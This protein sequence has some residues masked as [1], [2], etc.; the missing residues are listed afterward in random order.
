ML[1]SSALFASAGLRYLPPFVLL[2]LAF[3]FGRTLQPGEVPLIER[4]ARASMP[5]LSPALRRYTRGLTAAWC[6][7]FLF[8]ALLAVAANAGFRAASFG[9]ASA[10]ALFFVGEYWL[11]RQ[12]LFRDQAFPGLIQQVRDTA[13]VWRLR[14]VPDRSGADEPRG[15]TAS[16]KAKAERGSAG[17]IHAIAWAARIAGRPLCRALLCPITLYFVVTDATA[18]RASRE[19]LSRALGRPAALADVFAHIYSFATTLLDR[20]YMASGDF[21]R[22]SITVTGDEL[23]R[24][25]LASGKGCVLLGSHLG[26]FD[27]MTLKNKVL[28][29]RPVTLLM[30][31][32][33]RSRVRRIA[34]ID[35][36]KL[37][38][39]PLGRFDSYLRAYEVLARGGVVAVLADRSEQ[40]AAL[41]SEF[42]GRP[43]WFPLGPHALAARADAVVLVGFGL[44]EGGARYRVEIVE[45][46]AP[47]PA[48]S[49]GSALQPAVDRYVALLEQYA[50]RYPL[51]WFNF[52]PYWQQQRQP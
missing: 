2:W 43:A 47:A 21:R 49:R 30:H 5:P 1:E 52:F 41:Q 19:F 26:S 32:D 23:V 34:G 22:F 51:N 27:L 4:I 18:R 3:F 45:Y 20:V 36:S 44:Y 10:S 48:G 24:D 9:V 12:I 25:A 33:E 28:H 16:W 29:D 46:G 17:L 35:D 13:A 7:Y 40:A 37:S 8:A 6:G 14:D 31:F 42:L 15:E 39:I 50:R 38:V 11:R